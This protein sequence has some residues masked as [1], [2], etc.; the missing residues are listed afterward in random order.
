MKIEGSKNVLLRG[1]T[2]V[3]NAISTRS[4]LPILSNILLETTGSGLSIVGT[5]L[6]VGIIATIPVNISAA[7]SITLPAKRF[8][9]IIKELPESSVTISVK[10]NNM[11]HITC[12]NTQFKIMGI[13]K[14]EFPKLPEFKNK[15][16]VKLDQSL[17]KNMLSMTAFAM[18]R[19]ETRYILN[20]VHMLIKKNTIRMVATDGR[21]LALIEKEATLEKNI[22]KSIIIPTKAVQELLRNLKD[23]GEVTVSFSENQMMFNL[24]DI[25]IISRLIEGE[26]PN[27]E[28]VIPK[29]VKEKIVVDREKLLLATKRASLLTT[30]DSQAVKIDVEKDKMVVSKNSPDIGE[31]REEISVDYKGPSLSIGFN[32]NYIMDALKNLNEETIGFEIQDPE[33]PGVIRT[34]EKYI[35]V[36]LPMQLT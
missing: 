5:D 7:G 10:K 22:E 24:G 21:R 4:A 6:D 18:S 28:Q 13:P 17:L 35:Y 32:P 36:V 26:F 1:I 23:D 29:E 12:E 31:A 9:D 33:K 16:A 2:A 15:D 8:A 19:D 34:K 20:G 27:Y 11:A 14:D 3:Q 30:P 25:V